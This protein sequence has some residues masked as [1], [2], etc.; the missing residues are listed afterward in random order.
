MRASKL[1]SVLVVGVGTTVPVVAFAQSGSVNEA[2]S[3][4][5][6]AISVPTEGTDEA[7]TFRV[8]DG[9]YLRMAFGFGY[10]SMSF[11]KSQYSG[12]LEAS[13][14]GIDASLLIGGTPGRGLVIGGMFTGADMFAN[15]GDHLSF[16]FGPFI[17]VYP[18]PRG[19]WHMGFMLGFS[20]QSV[21][22]SEDDNQLFMIWGG[23]ASFWAGYEAW[24][25]GDWSMGGML[26]AQGSFG[27]RERGPTGFKEDVQGR[28]I[29]ITLNATSV[30]Q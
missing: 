17:D 26:K 20:G 5:S 29:S 25:S 27:G 18:N 7:R 11:T 2:T 30:F 24:V 22:D 16:A 4:V 28:A 10:Q 6:M 8:H 12:G 13:G 1:L 21:R 19:G 3:D 23:A 9:F 15:K 14:A